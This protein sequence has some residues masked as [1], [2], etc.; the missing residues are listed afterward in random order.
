MPPVAPPRKPMRMLLRSAAVFLALLV[1]LGPAWALD[2][3][4]VEIASKTGVHV[5]SVEIADTEAAREKGSLPERARR[6]RAAARAAR[7]MI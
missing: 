2:R 4:T 6:D 3:N 7:W 5:F 1:T